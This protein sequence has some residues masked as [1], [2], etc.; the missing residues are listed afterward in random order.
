MLL[1]ENGVI[2]PIFNTDGIAQADGL[3]HLTAAFI[4]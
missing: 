2:V 1:R 3:R 4:I